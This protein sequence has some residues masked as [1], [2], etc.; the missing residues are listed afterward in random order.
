MYSP[1]CVTHLGL[2]NVR[3]KQEGGGSMSLVLVLLTAACVVHLGIVLWVIGNNF[4]TADIPEGINHPVKLRIFHCLFQLLLTWGG[5]FEKFGI[6]SATQFVSFVHD[7]PPLKKYPGVVVTDLRFGTIPVRLYRP[8]APTSASRPGVIFYH[9]GGA[10]LGSLKTHHGFCS[11]LCKKSDSVVLAVKYRKSPKYKHPVMTRDCMVATI[12]FLKSLNKYGVDPRRVVVCG[13][14]V[15]GGLAA[16]L[17]QIFVNHPDLPRI[18]AQILIYAF[19]QCLDFQSPSYQQN[20]NVPLLTWDFAFYCWSCHLNISPSWQSTVRKG[21]HLPPEVWERLRKWLGPENIPE[22]FKKRGYHPVSREPVDIEAYQEISI[23]LHWTSSPLIN[24]DDI[25]AQVPEACIISCEYDL[26]RD[27]SVLYKKRLE[28]V[29]VPVTWHHVEDG[30]HG[31]LATIDL[32]CMQFSC[33]MQILDAVVHFIK[34]L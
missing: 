22:R 32:G 2:A 7:L 3:R 15:G 31:V 12:H 6:C 4:A 27:H 33:S 21:A 28:D 23:L 5:I 10:V 18:R 24:S 19:L 16:V 9:G 25:V 1:E 17:C 14:S 20:R 26:L 34:E 29:G 11:F 30:F 13:E 8:E